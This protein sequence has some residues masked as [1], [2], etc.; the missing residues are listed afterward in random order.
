MMKPEQRAA[1][2][3]RREAREQEQAQW[4][5]VAEAVA[6]I[7][8]R[9]RKCEAR[10]DRRIA[11]ATKAGHLATPPTSICPERM[12]ARHPDWRLRRLAR[13]QAKEAHEL[14]DLFYHESRPDIEHHQKCR[15][16]SCRPAGYTSMAMFA[17]NDMTQRIAVGKARQ[18]RLWEKLGI[19]NGR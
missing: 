9:P 13:R 12:F 18:A 6:G 16:L 1:M 11:L 14:N 10:L 17:K 8:M 19:R 7:K 4:S 15:G 5:R 3:A 2:L